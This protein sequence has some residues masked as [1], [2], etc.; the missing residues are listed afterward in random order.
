MPR[1]RS[2]QHG[3]QGED[4][5]EANLINAQ[6]SGANLTNADL[7]GADL[8]SAVLTGADLTNAN[9]ANAFLPYIVSG[10]I[11]GV[12]RV[13]PA[14]WTLVN[15]FL[16]G[17]WANLTGADLTGADLTN[18]NLAN[19]NLT[20]AI[21]TRTTLTRV[22]LTNA[23]LTDV[24]SGGLIDSPNVLPTGWAIVNGYLIG[25]WANLTGA[26]L[27]NATLAGAKFAAANLTDVVSSGLVDAP[28][29]LPDGWSIVDGT[30]VD[31]RITAP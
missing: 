29:S 19:T 5:T 6:L 27:T 21:L 31:G 18:T 26:N 16:I 10:R 4:L 28:A 25:H 20:A 12:P 14:G 17:P 2:R 8:T 9:L 24:I 22:D 23:N 7:S 11:I 30:I 3:P 1:R 15:G 13:L